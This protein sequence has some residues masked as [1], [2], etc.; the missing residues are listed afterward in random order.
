MRRW[1]K[2]KSV[3]GSCSAVDQCSCLMSLPDFSW[4]PNWTCGGISRMACLLVFTTENNTITCCPVEDL[5]DAR[6]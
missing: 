2:R 4:P 1:L 5:A 6:P 3:T